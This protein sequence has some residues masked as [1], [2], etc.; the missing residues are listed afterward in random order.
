MLEDAG[1]EGKRSRKIEGRDLQQLQAHG[2]AMEGVESQDNTSGRDGKTA[3]GG[4]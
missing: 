2:T 3:R 4:S 1:E